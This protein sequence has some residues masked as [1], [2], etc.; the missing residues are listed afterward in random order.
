LP[1]PDQSIDPP[2][3]Q[4][5][6]EN[7]RKLISA[8]SHD[9]RTPLTV[10]K[11]DIEVSLLRDRTPEQYQEVL[12]SNLEEVD[13]MGRLLE[14]LIILMRAETGDLRAALQKT[15][16]TELIAG[17]F[18]ELQAAAKGKGI[19]FQLES[20]EPVFVKADPGLCRKLFLNIFE[21]AVQYSPGGGTVTVALTR[22]EKTARVL[23]RDQGIGVSPQDATQVF[24]PLFRGGQA[25][26]L[27]PKGYGLGLAVCKKIIFV[28]NGSLEIESRADRQTGAAFTVVLP[29]ERG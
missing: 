19:Q 13:R 9:L 7:L 24:Q 8:L 27:A 1:K 12:R 28:H 4:T 20:A 14:D 10:I 15:D 16:L 17:L 18:S 25:R 23:V 29:V 2:A 5:R 6:L 21:N 22:D 11:G 26:V 3:D